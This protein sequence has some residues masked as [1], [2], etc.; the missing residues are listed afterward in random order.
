[1]R[2]A[3]LRLSSFDTVV[4]RGRHALAGLVSLLRRLRLLEG[5]GPV[6]LERVAVACTQE[7]VPAGAVVLR[8]GDPPDDLFV[9]RGPLRR[10]K[11]RAARP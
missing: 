7:R 9:L 1:M 11:A 2:V 8:Q 5:A 4:G 3:L 10:W 6:G